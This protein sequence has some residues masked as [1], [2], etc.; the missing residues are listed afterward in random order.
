M[1]KVVVIGASTAGLACAAHLKK[2][3]IP[4]RLLEKHAVVGNAWRNHYDRLHLHTNK[5][6]STLPFVE[7]GRD[8]PKY[9]SK[10]QVIDYLENYVREMDLQPEFN[11]TVNRLS[12]EDEH[13]LIETNKGTIQS[14]HV[15]VCTGNTNKARR[16]NKPGL[17]SFPGKIIHSSE[18]KNGN[19]FKDQNVLVM[20]FGNSA[21]EI[22]MDLHEN[23]A[24]ASLSVRS[25]V[26]VIPRDILG[27]PVL[28]IGIVQGG[29][30]PR[31]R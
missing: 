9:P 24:K 21:C 2:A 22:A 23:G 6:N 27:I 25:A 13:W 7:Y 1:E 19:E 29:L 30:P 18:Y 26:N 12:K 16:V 5:G 3:G 15:I 31:L 4:F 14:E 17:D 11:T 28:A 10:Q 20:G 8:I